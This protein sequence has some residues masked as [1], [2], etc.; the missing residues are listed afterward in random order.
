[1]Q[2]MVDNIMGDEQVNF[3]PDPPPDNNY[4]FNICSAFF[5]AS[6]SAF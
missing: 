5:V 3:S 1:M 2:S 4:L 6:S